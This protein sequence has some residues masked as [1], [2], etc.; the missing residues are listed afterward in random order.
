MFKFTG[1]ADSK[2]FISS[3]SKIQTNHACPSSSVSPGH[4]H[5]NMTSED[6]INVPTELSKLAV[7]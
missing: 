3:L 5:V 4:C 6:S 2:P 1:I 7:L